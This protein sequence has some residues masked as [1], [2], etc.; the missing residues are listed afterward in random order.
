MP[1]LEATLQQL[2]LLQELTLAP[3]MLDP[4][5]AS[6]GAAL[7]GLSYLTRLVLAS[8][9]SEPNSHALLTALAHALP[10]LTQLKELHVA[11]DMHA[12]AEMQM[13]APSPQQDEQAAAVEAGQGFV[14]GAGDVVF[15]L[16]AA[17][18][19]Q[20]ASLVIKAL[21]LSLAKLAFQRWRA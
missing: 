14:A 18:E 9:G 16:M 20:A 5:A 6:V 19:H 2:P 12:L 8:V 17:A 3:C 15:Q 1:A 7:G 10:C 13:P 4:D 11:G 21:F